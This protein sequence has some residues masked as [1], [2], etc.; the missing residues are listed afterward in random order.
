MDM[1]IDASAGVN[2]YTALASTSSSTSVQESSA[3]GARERAHVTTPQTEGSLGSNASGIAASGRRVSV[4]V[5]DEKAQSELRRKIMDIQ[6]D[7]TISFTD[8]AGMIQ[9]LMSSK[10]HGSQRSTESQ[11]DG[12]VEA[13]ADDLRKTFHNEEQGQLGCKHYIRGCKLK[14]DCCGKWFNC[15]FCHDDASDHAIIRSETKTM[16]C[17]HCQTVQAAAQ[18]CNSCKACLATH[19]CDICK[20][21]DDDSKKSIYHCDDCGL[22][23]I[24]QGL[25]KDYFHCR[26]CN[27]CMNIQLQGNHKCIERNLECDCPI[28]G[29]YMFTSTTT[30]I[31]M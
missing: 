21:W 14:A 19:Y 7:S 5:V 30:V 1:Q 17:M 23:R 31:F 3:G 24:G 27:V 4:P 28:C 22:C 15:R 13:T 6:R 10:W 12:S 16:L 18:T 26:K 20:L 2:H 9:K 25:G 29:E 8:K 11:G